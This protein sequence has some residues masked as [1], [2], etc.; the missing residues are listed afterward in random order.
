MSMLIAIY[1][2]YLKENIL[3]AVCIMHGAIKFTSNK[4]VSFSFSMTVK[5]KAHD[6]IVKFYNMPRWSSCG[7]YRV[8]IYWEVVSLT[9]GRTRGGYPY[10]TEFLCD[11][12][13]ALKMFYSME[14]PPPLFFFSLTLI[15][16]E[17]I[18]IPLLSFLVVLFF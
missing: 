8:F 1:V 6:S 9:P 14:R 10:N 7:L 12:L 2:L 4:Y 11:T 17:R 15:Y 13:M 3:N 16:T 18:L 5:K